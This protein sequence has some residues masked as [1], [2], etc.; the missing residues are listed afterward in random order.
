MSQ[1]RRC[2]PPWKAFL[3]ILICAGLAWILYY[4]NDYVAACWCSGIAGMFLQDWAYRLR[5][6]YDPERVL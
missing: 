6:K 4:E 5:D 3:G 2:L 1:T